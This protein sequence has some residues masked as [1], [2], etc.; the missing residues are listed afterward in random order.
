MTTTNETTTNNQEN[1]DP[2]LLGATLRTQRDVYVVAQDLN[3]GLRTARSQFDCGAWGGSRKKAQ[4]SALA[5][6]MEACCARLPPPPDDK[7]RPAVEL[8]ALWSTAEVTAWLHRVVQNL[9]KIQESDPRELHVRHLLNEARRRLAMVEAWT[10]ASAPGEATPVAV[11]A[12][13]TPSAKGSAAARKAW[14][15]IRA[16][17]AAAEEVGLTDATVEVLAGMALP[18]EAAKAFSTWS[19]VLGQ[20]NAHTQKLLKLDAAARAALD[21]PK[22]TPVEAASW[23][24]KLISTRAKY[25]KLKADLAAASAAAKEADPTLHAEIHQ[26]AI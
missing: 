18:P 13:K 11:P 6:G 4:K 23:K 3:V 8:F 15:T 14:D 16:K 2:L 26:G 9:S 20:R 19:K 12:K 25:F 7:H 5:T 22:L 21:N 10:A 1:H 17:K 24:A